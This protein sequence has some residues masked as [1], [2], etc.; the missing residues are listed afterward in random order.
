M[1]CQSCLEAGKSKDIEL[2]KMS[3]FSPTFPPIQE[4]VVVDM[5]SFVRHV[6]EAEMLHLTVGKSPDEVKH[7]QSRIHRI[8]MDFYDVSHKSCRSHR[9]L[10]QRVSLC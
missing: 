3:Y 9:H 2:K 7:D 4:E 6:L 1:E 5:E 10:L 8:C